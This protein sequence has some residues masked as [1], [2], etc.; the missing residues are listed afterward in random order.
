MKARDALRAQVGSA[1]RK[2]GHS[3]LTLNKW[4]AGRHAAYSIMRRQMGSLS[5]ACVLVMVATNL[6]P[7]LVETIP[8]IRKD[9]NERL[10]AS[11]CRRTMLSWLVAP[12]M[13]LTGS[14]PS[15]ASEVD[16]GYE[17]Q[18]GLK[19]GLGKKRTR[20]PGFTALPSG[21]QVKDVNPG[22]NGTSEAKEGDFVVFTWEGY[23]INYFGRPFET[24]TLQK[25]AGVEPNP[26]R[27]QVL[28]RDFEECEKVELSYDEEKRLG[29]RPTTAG[30]NRA[31][32]FVMDNK[33]GLM[34][35]ASVLNHILPGAQR[36]K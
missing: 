13:S 4:R 27:C 12:V 10:L 18:E 11:P 24:Q 34:V 2:P 30:G 19:P 33:G 6:P 29:P 20:V 32:D 31:L 25:M 21:L 14:F 15:M 26:V 16:L 8:A 36:G 1:S 17:K 22:R 7:S 5:C 23:T 28:M 9:Q 3:S 35:P